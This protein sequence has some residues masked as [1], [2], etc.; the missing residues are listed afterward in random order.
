MV[1]VYC[2]ADCVSVHQRCRKPAPVAYNSPM[3]Y[4][5][6]VST[7]LSVD[8]GQGL[9]QTDDQFSVGLVKAWHYVIYVNQICHGSKYGF[10]INII[11][12]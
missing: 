8:Y 4:P 7:T 12:L 11:V 10:C 9:Y 3:A 2:T 5:Q 6:P 1:V